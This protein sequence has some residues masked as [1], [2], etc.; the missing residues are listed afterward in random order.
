VNLESRNQIQK[1]D[2]LFEIANSWLS[3][4]DVARILSVTPNAVRI[5][6]C[7]GQLPSFKFKNQLRFRFKDC[8][9]LVEKQGA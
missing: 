6:V 5:M 7:R 9:A 3:T 4:K 8:A 1:S 2:A